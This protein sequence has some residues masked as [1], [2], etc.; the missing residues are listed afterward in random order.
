MSLV[1]QRSEGEGRSGNGVDAALKD[2]NDGCC[3][4]DDPRF[5]VIK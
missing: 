1:S 5:E 4:D 2:G 3:K